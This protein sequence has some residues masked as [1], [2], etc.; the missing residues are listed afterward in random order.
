MSKPRNS[1]IYEYDFCPDVGEAIDILPGLKWLRLPLP[2]M[3]GHINVWLLKD[4]DCWAIVDTGIF[5]SDTR[6]VWESI[7]TGCMD[8]APVSQ[9]LVTHLHPDHVGCAGWLCRRYEVELHMTRDEYLLC[10]ILVADT[11]LPAPHEGRRFYQGAGF[12]EENMFRYVEM[13]GSFGKVV[14]ELPRSYHRLHED[15]AVNIGGQQWQV[16]TGHGHSPE[17]A[18]LYNPQMN[19]L[20]SGDQVLPTISPNVSV[21]PTEPSANPLSGWFESLHRFKNELPDD[22]LVLP[23]HGKPFRGVKGRLDELIE[24]HEVGLDKLRDFCQ[25]PKRAVDVF[26]SL[27][28]S[29][30]TDSNLL[31]ATGEAIAHL[32]YLL[33]E[34][35]VSINTDYD[36]TRWYQSRY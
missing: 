4:G 22:V 34:G 28:K 11:G 14:C 26:P 33:Y 23:A 7:F 36:G 31:M 10:R 20:I 32:N 18:C 6:K 35:E 29:K 25:E 19:V 13:F 5:S 9:V 12:S 24:E 17:H 1:L 2:F 30:I 21:Y 27:F 3:L 16:M 8:N 15:Q